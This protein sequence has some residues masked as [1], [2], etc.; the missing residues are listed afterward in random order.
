MRFLKILLI[1]IVV[2]VLAVVILGLT[3][4]KTYQVERT[5]IISASPDIVWPYAGNAE[6]FQEWSPFRK[7]D[8]TARV[9]F[10][11]NPG[12]VGSGF[13]WKGKSSGRGESTYT[14]LEPGKSAN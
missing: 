10:F 7:L 4:P 3:G 13:K 8:T 6:A 14:V 1:V 12:T 2:L 9:E 5:A 11:G